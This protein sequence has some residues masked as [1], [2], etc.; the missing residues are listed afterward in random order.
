MLHLFFAEHLMCICFTFC[1]CRGARSALAPV[2]LA[3]HAS[4]EEGGW[5]VRGARL[6]LHEVGL[7]MAALGAGRC[8]SKEVTEEACAGHAHIYKHYTG[9]APRQEVPV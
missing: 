5:L 8:A 9:L 6:H 7:S 4:E 3:L 2:V 1:M